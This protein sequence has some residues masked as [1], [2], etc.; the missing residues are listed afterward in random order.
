[1]EAAPPHLL[2]VV[3]TMWLVNMF[4]EAFRRLRRV[5]VHLG[6][7]VHLSLPPPNDLLQRTVKDFA[8]KI[9]VLSRGL[10][11]VVVGPDDDDDDSDDGGFDGG[12]DGSLDGSDSDSGAPPAATTYA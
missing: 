2:N 9:N 5:V 8:F 6:V 1:M 12:D 11:R 4:L 3:D 10:E 7:D